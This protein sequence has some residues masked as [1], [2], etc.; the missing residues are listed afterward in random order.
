MK[1]YKKKRNE[2]TCTYPYNKYFFFKTGIF[3]CN[4]YEFYRIS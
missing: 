3:K 2:N 4:L 1:I